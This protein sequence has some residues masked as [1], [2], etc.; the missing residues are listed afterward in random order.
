MEIK[1]H[2]RG[3][4]ISGKQIP[5]VGGGWSAS[6]YNCSQFIKKSRCIGIV[7]ESQ[8]AGHNKAY[9]LEHRITDAL[10]ISLHNPSCHAAKDVVRYSTKYNIIKLGYYFTQQQFVEDKD[11]AYHEDLLFEKNNDLNFDKIKNSNVFINRD[12]VIKFIKDSFQNSEKIDF[13]KLIKIIKE[14]QL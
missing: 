5:N 13:N 9:I 6:R 14:N 10:T 2:E 3:L 8:K 7:F 11:F 4:N 1:R 12:V